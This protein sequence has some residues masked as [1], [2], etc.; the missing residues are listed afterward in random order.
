MFPTFIQSF[1][2]LIS[3]TESIG[4][5]RVRYLK[6]DPEVV[7]W[8]GKHFIMF[9]LGGHVSL[10]FIIGFPILGLYVLHVDQ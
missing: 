2:K 4:A 5:E 7:C 3:C 8:R 1:A 6:I 10:T 9:C